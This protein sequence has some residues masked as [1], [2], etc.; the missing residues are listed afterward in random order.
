[1]VQVLPVPALASIRRLPQ[2]GTRSGSSVSD[3]DRVL[4]MR[5]CSRLARDD[6]DTGG[7]PVEHRPVDP[8]GPRFKASIGAECFEV[9]KAAS[10]TRLRSLPFPLEAALVHSL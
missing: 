9:W 5:R 1:M 3:M 8:L 7:D 4:G 2:S 6:A 10:E